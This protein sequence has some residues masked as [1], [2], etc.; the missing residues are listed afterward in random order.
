MCLTEVILLSPTAKLHSSHQQLSR[1]KHLEV[2]HCALEEQC[3]VC[4]TLRNIVRDWFRGP[5]RLANSLFSA[6][7]TKILIV[8]SSSPLTERMHKYCSSFLALKFS[9]DT[10]ETHPIRCT[11]CARNFNVCAISQVAGNSWILLQ[12]SLLTR[13]KWVHIKK[14]NADNQ[15]VYEG[16]CQIQPAN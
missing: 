8:R 2:L 11:Q 15:L 3:V 1:T 12:A 5:Q 14:V 9:A 10:M 6:R 7:L 13:L 4:F 16:L